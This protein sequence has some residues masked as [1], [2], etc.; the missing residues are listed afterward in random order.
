MKYKRRNKKTRRRKKRKGG[1][2]PGPETKQRMTEGVDG[3]AALGEKTGNLANKMTDETIRVGSEANQERKKNEE[4]NIQKYTS[5]PEPVGGRKR[6]RKRRKSLKKKRKSRRISRKK[7]KRRK[8]RK[9]RRRR[10]R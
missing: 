2:F 10:K 1:D 4:L 5:L 3:L 6:R 8:R 9:T 7:S